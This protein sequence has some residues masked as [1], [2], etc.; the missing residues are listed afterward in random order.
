MSNRIKVSYPAYFK[1]FKCVGGKCEDTCCKAWNIEMDKE[2][3]EFYYS[4]KDKDMEKIIKNSILINE[5]C[6][7][8]NIDYGIIKLNHKN[9]CPFLDDNYYCIIQNKY[10]E[11]HLSEVCA[12]FPRIINKV[13]NKYEISLDI[14][15]PEAAKIIL[16][17][18]EKIIIDS[19]EIDISKYI[20]NDEYDTNSKKYINTPVKYFKEIRDYSIKIMQN[21]KYNISTRLYILGQFI[22]RLEET[23]YEDYYSIPE[24][25]SQFSMKNV[26]KFYKK[27]KENYI[28]Q[29]I[30]FKNIIDSLQ[31]GE[32]QISKV[33]TLYT[34]K[35]LNKFQ[36]NDDLYRNGQEYINVFDNYEKEIVEN[37]SYIFENYIVNFMCNTLF[38]FSENDFMFDGYIMLLVR[39]AFIRFYLVGIYTEDENDI[40]CKI[41][42]FIT[43]FTR[44]VEHNKNYLPDIL[45]YIN[46]NCFN[47][48][49]FAR[50][51]L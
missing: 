43:A 40:S 27:D 29:I 20:V 36:I 50:R 49:N 9:L 44:T 4:I 42:K 46:S 35:L 47:N 14:A 2:T 5:E 39:Y 25:I 32:D 8:C 12:S 15:C 48:F 38:P 7:N 37:Y 22:C 23:K 26:V 11:E 24:V 16:N 10:G 1:S 41:I 6:T 19:S 34:E 21:R 33:F 13:D 45:K 30:F 17:S 28:F 31:I 18:K 3:F 51:L